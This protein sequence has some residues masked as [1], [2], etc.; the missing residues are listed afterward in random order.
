MRRTSDPRT[1]YCATSDRERP[2]LL[3]PAGSNRHIPAHRRAPKL[4]EDRTGSFTFRICGT[5]VRGLRQSAT[6]R[7]CRPA[8]KKCPGASKKGRT[9][10]TSLSRSRLEPA[11]SGHSGGQLNEDLVSRNLALLY[12]CLELQ[13][14]AASLKA[15]LQ[16]LQQPAVRTT[17]RMVKGAGDSHGGGT[18]SVRPPLSAGGDLDVAT[19]WKRS[20]SQQG[21]TYVVLSGRPAVRT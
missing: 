7:P 19:G 1:C 18:C 16:T 4:P 20:G 8:R 6:S 12:L 5:I 9:S 10:A 13:L 21:I 14:E 17:R 11:M 15:R 3:G 2:I